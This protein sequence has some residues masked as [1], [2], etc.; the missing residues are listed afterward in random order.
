MLLSL[1]MDTLQIMENMTDSY[2]ETVIICITKHLRLLLYLLYIYADWDNK[3]Q[4]N[5]NS[6]LFIW[7]TGAFD[8][9]S[10]GFNGKLGSCLYR[11]E[12]QHFTLRKLNKSY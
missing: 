2:L 4:M 6:V 9:W 3:L 7:H 11:Q 5:T 12:N 1:N 10:A 8:F